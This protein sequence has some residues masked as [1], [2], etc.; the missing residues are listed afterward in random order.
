MESETGWSR[1]S[2][3]VWNRRNNPGLQPLKSRIALTCVPQRLKPILRE[4]SNAGL[5][6]L[7]HPKHIL[8]LTKSIPVASMV[9]IS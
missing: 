9:P 2:R 7:L 8:E 5:Q 6:A 4:C 3:P 1:P